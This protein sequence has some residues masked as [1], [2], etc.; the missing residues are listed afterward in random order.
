VSKIPAMQP[1]RTFAIVLATFAVPALAADVSG[2]AALT[3][4]YVWRGT[5]QTQGEPA[6]QAGIKWAAKSGA[7]ASLWAS[8]VDFGPGSD[9]TSEWDLAV[10]WNATLPVKQLALDAYVLHY[11]YPSIAAALDWTELNGTLTVAQRY[12][13]SVGYSPE[14]L[15]SDNDGVYAQLGA[16]F[17]VH[18]RLRFEAA[19]ARYFLDASYSHGQLS[20]VW[21]FK[22]PFEVR[23]SAHATDRQAKTLFGAA[24]AGTRFEAALQTSF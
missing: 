3:T 4:D 1:T 22:V 21:T 17:P 12:W 13:V 11:R 15:G 24:N 8:N 19:F 20:A 7:Y 6:A 2:T 18:E 9:A 16:R 14:A 5:T 10:G 23:L